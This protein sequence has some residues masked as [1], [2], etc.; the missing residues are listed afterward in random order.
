MTKLLAA[1]GR[2]DESA[3]ERLWAMIYDE[4]HGIARQQMADEAAPRT[5][6]PTV[7]VHEAYLR[8]LGGDG[9]IRW[10]NRR[11]FFS[12]AAKIMRH[13]RIDDARKRKSL[14][15]GGGESPRALEGELGAFDQDPTEVLAVHEALAKLEETEPRRAEVVVLRYFAGLGVDE[16]AE[17]IGVSPRTVDAD[18]RH[19]RAWLHRELS[20]GDTSMGP[21]ICR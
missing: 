17:V 2:G 19:A 10:A 11:Q 13:I 21:D 4:L 9:D 6:Q 8:L 20:R 15:R 5:M 18:W 16:V 12:V 14:K 7:L 1:V 3:H